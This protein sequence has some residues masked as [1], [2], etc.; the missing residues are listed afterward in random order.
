[1]IITRNS[2]SDDGNSGSDDE[3]RNN[4]NNSDKSDINIIIVEIKTKRQIIFPFL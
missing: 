3:K 2:G 1:M 4:N